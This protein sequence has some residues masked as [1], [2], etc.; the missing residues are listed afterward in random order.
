MTRLASFVAAGLLAAAPALVSAA[1]LAAP[2]IAAAEVTAAPFV[3]HEIMARTVACEFQITTNDNA[4]CLEFA[5]EWGLSVAQFEAL[6][7]TAM[8]PNL[9]PDT[10]YCVLGTVTG[11]SSSGAIGPNRTPTTVSYTLPT[12][13][14]GL[15]SLDISFSTYPTTTTST[16]STA[17]TSTSTTSTS[18]TTSSKPAPTQAGL[19]ANC[20]NF[21]LVVKGDS[22]AT[23]ESAY[24]VSAADFLSWN[25][26]VQSNCLG[27]LT[28]YYV[29]VGVS[30]ATTTVKSTSISTTTTT[31]SKTTST[32][33]TTSTTSM[34][35]SKTSTASA[36]PSPLQPGTF[37]NCTSYH[38]VVAGDSCSAIETAAGISTA[39]FEMWNSGVNAGCT[40]IDVGYYLCVG[41]GGGSVSTI[42][43]PLQPGTFDNC[44]QYHEVVS[45]DSCAAIESAAGITSAQFAAWNSGVNAGCTNIDVGYY[46]CIAGGGGVVSSVPSPLQ[47]GTEST[48]TQYHLVVS[49][50]SC[51][52]IE[53]AAGISA[54]QFAAWNSGVNAGCTNIQVGYYLCIAGGSGTVSSTPSP[55]QP[56]T[57]STCITYHLVVSGD[58][59]SAIE[60][61][62]GITAAQFA[63]WNPD[64]NSACTNIELGYYVCIGA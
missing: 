2:A 61:A 17:K 16:T 29:C 5:S 32:T 38:L 33:T 37:D 64:V 21:H 55:L 4:T 40:N 23:I 48:C 27:L 34:S 15:S 1:A 58:S 39:Q 44:T 59:C 25:P 31:T 11:A 26:A 41:G 20:N 42:P 51:S 63:A 43:S 14:G 7:P 54:A 60:S 6:N 22:C 56:G 36:V 47:P 8:C 13:T 46:L 10:L 35:T 53:S 18:T 24:G 12:G 50:D 57:I 19:T 52:A 9:T 30:G 62:A 3:G 45:G 28:H 49:G